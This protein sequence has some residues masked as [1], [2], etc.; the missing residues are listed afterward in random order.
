MKKRKG[1]LE[2]GTFATGKQRAAIAPLDHLYHFPHFFAPIFSSWSQQLSHAMSQ[3]NT[4]T[5]T[6]TII[7]HP[8]PAAAPPSPNRRLNYHMPGFHLSRYNHHQITRHPI[9]PGIPSISTY[10]N[11]YHP[12]SPFSPRT[13]KSSSYSPLLSKQAPPKA[14]PFGPVAAVEATAGLLPPPGQS[15]RRHGYVTETGPI[16]NSPF[17][18]R[19]DDTSTGAACSPALP[20]PTANS[21]PPPPDKDSQCT[22][23]HLPLQVSAPR[24]NLPFR[25]PFFSSS[26]PIC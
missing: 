21:I 9:K 26:S 11:L 15:S 22:S 6:I 4:N 24:T 20:D 10:D 19:C 25:S 16:S 3:V 18:P 17:P 7:N 23:Q 12:C 5:N 8:Q 1:R 14:R 2:P 13:I